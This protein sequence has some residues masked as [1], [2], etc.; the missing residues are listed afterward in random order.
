MNKAQ[1]KYKRETG[2]CY[3]KSIETRLV[4][5]ALDMRCF[6]GW[7][8]EDIINAIDSETPSWGVLVSELPKEYDDSTNIFLPT[9]EYVQWL[10]EQII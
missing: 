4:V 8:Q 3:Y 2:N 9:P 5:D 10:E 6:E 7:K 1:L